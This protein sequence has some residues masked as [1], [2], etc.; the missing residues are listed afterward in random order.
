VERTVLTST[1]ITQKTEDIPDNNDSVSISDTQSSYN[2]HLQ[3]DTSPTLRTSPNDNVR[4]LSKLITDLNN[5]FDRLPKGTVALPQ[6][7]VAEP[8][9]IKQLPALFG[10]L[11]KLLQQ[12]LTEEQNQDPLLSKLKELFQT[13]LT[14]AQKK[15]LSFDKLKP[16]LE[17]LLTPKQ[18]EESS[19][20]AVLQKSLKPQLADE[21]KKELSIADLEN[22]FKRQVSVDAKDKIIKIAKFH[23]ASQLSEQLRN[24]PAGLPVEELSH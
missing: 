24:L 19:L 13:Q 10:D 3:N 7:N 18:K 16:I 22:V 23:L 1:S 5:E 4:T 20:T 9:D 17:P 21:S 6:L 2:S 15:E 12:Q 8:L 14:D 11:Q